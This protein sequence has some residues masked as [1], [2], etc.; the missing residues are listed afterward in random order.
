MGKS[1]ASSPPAVAA[2]APPSAKVPAITQCTGMPMRAA[3]SRSSAQAPNARAHLAVRRAP[4]S[5]E[6]EQP[7]VV[8]EG[9]GEEGAEREQLADGELNDARQA[10]DDGDAQGYERVDATDPQRVEELLQELC[11][12]L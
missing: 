7:V 8:P 6:E 5:R 4:D 11:Q 12:V 1:D 2:S 3:A 10:K 9:E